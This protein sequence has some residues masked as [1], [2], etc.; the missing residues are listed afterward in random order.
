MAHPT[1]STLNTLAG[2]AI[3]ATA[4]A[5]ASS[6]GGSTGTSGSGSS[7]GHALKGPERIAEL[8]AEVARLQGE[9]DR[10]AQTNVV[11][12]DELQWAHDDLK[13]VERQFSE[14]EHRL[15][16]DFGKAA[17]VSATA[18]ARIHLQTV[19]K[20]VALPDSS[21][22]HVT[23]LLETAEQLIRS[24]NYP[25][26]FF[27]AERANHTLQGAERRAALDVQASTMTVAA[28]TANVREGPGQNYDVRATLRQGE[29]VS[30]LDV[31]RNWCHVVTATGATGWVHASLL[32]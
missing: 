29:R 13:L 5:C 30:C 25:A 18:E 7:S 21:V 14:F 10:L 1:R 3:L 8:E 2:V 11:L 22:K 16:E 27:F 12:E 19:Q 15:T 20:T 23:S 9:R 31:S 24:S 4:V 28:A 32:R 17:A 6:G 26:A